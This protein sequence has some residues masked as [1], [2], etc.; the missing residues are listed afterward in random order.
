M[1]LVVFNVVLESTSTD[2]VVAMSRE[3]VVDSVIVALSEAE[4]VVFCSM[5]AVVV[6]LRVA[7]PVVELSAVSV[8]VAFADVDVVVFCAKDVM[9]AVSIESEVVDV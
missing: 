5:R 7:E 1:T 3:T 2:A 9:V 6:V 8:T 4:T